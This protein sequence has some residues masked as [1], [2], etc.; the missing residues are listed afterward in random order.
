M[1][2][3][4]RTDASLQIGT[5]HLMR[6]LALADALRAQGADIRFIA[7]ELQGAPLQAICDHGYRL[8]SL[9]SPNTAATAGNGCAHAHWLEVPQMV[10]A[11]QTRERLEA[12]GGADLLIVDHYALDVAWERA[13]RAV[14]RRICVL[15][16]LADR[17]HDCDLLL[18]QTPKDASRYYTKVPAG[19]GLMLGPAYA[20]LRT[21]FS[22]WRSKMSARSGRVRRLLVCFGGVDAANHTARVL[23]ALQRLKQLDLQLDVVAGMANPHVDELRRLCAQMSK[24]RFLLAPRNLAEL[25]AQADLAVGAGGVM[26]WERACLGLPTLAV[27]VADN[28]RPV[29]EALAA[30]GHIACVELAE[31]TPE[32]VAAVLEELIA[33]PGRL[34]EMRRRNLALVDGRGCERAARVL[35][36]PTINLRIA[37]E[38]DRSALF[39]WRN[40]EEVRRHSNDPQPISRETHGRW[41]S[42]TLKNRRKILLIAEHKDQGA[43]GVLRYD[44]GGSEARISIYLV[45]GCGGRGYGPAILRAGQHW[46]QQHRPRVLCVSA[47]ILPGNTASRR[48]FEEAGYR[49][50]RSL[51]RQSLRA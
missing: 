26:T 38:S 28:Q 3:A 44:L 45:P 46:L 6:C 2:L 7:R 47:E 43:V 4:I 5:G 36:P 22:R 50:E 51:F 15:D 30:S 23:E 20:L 49:L 48:A 19:C 17:L 41:F 32:R 29:M 14:A 16:D 8:E 27:V 39:L 13:Q 18:D 37:V 11:E 1:R 34:H 35:I 9:P 25:M 42:E 12:A 31:F 21:E 24:A 33:E 10:D 40:D